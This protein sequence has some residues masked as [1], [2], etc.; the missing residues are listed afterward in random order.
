VPPQDLCF[1][2]VSKETCQDLTL[3]TLTKRERNDYYNRSVF[4]YNI[5]LSLTFSSISWGLSADPKG[6]KWYFS[7]LEPVLKVKN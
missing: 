3:R 5:I 4:W 2:S 1:K 6:E 7:D